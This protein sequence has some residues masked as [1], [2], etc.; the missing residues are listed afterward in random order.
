M[1]IPTVTTERLR[2]R[3]LS[4]ADLDD[5]ANLIYGDRE[6]ML[7][8]PESSRPARERAELSLAHTTEVWDRFGYGM[9]AVIGIESGQFL[10]HC[11]LNHIPETD[12][13]EVLYAFA[14]SAWGRG[15]ATEGARASVRFGYQQT[16]IDE[17]IGLVMPENIASRKV[18]E[19]AGLQLDRRATYFGYTVDR[20]TITRAR[21]RVDEQETWL[22]ERD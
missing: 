17:L 10:G 8:I 5:W 7:Y 21:Y 20:L 9:W 1:N 3:P 4:R 2:L 12:E 16:A 6:V 11:G 15:Y 22:V 18:L 19:N 13:V 14:K